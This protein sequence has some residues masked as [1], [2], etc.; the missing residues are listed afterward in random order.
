MK[1][2]YFLLII[3][4]EICTVNTSSLAAKKEYTP[5]VTNESS[6]T[7]IYNYTDPEKTNRGSAPSV[8]LSILKSLFIIGLLCAAGWIF[9][10][11]LAT[12][13]TSGEV[14]SEVFKVI[15]RYTIA[16]GRSL[17]IV[18]ILD[19]YAVVAFSENN[20][21]IL[22]E[23]KDPAELDRV[24]QLDLSLTS[25]NLPLS[26][27]DT[28]FSLLKTNSKQ[29]NSADNVLTFLKRQKEKLKRLNEGKKL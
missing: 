15:S 7:N 3:I 26:F 23:I 10:K 9:L 21:S 16:P 29:A 17:C 11:W 6:F 2:L 27:S 14:N 12:K 28:F 22:K 8:F 25:K 1:K 19:S 18:K 5:A 20:I 24:K 13:Q 4:F